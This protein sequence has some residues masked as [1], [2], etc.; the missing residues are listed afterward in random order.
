ME[1]AR[2]LLAESPVLKYSI[3]AAGVARI[4]EISHTIW[5]AIRYLARF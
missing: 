2:E 3:I 4:F 5:L 1:F